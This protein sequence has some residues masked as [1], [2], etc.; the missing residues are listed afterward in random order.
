VNDRPLLS[1]SEA[2]AVVQEKGSRRRRWR[3]V[4]F[5]TPPILATVCVL[6]LAGAAGFGVHEEHHPSQ[7]EHGPAGRLTP[8]GSPRIIYTVPGDTQ[9]P[10]WA[11]TGGIGDGVWSWDVGTRSTINYVSGV[12]HRERV[13]DL[14]TACCGGGDRAFPGLTVGPSGTVWGVLNHTL[15]ELNPVTGRFATTKLPSPP[16]AENEPATDLVM[17]QNSA[18]DVT[19]ASD[20]RELV[21][22]F[23]YAAGVV[24]YPLAGGKLGRPSVIRLPAPD[25]ALDVGVLADGTL[26]V[27]MEEFGSSPR[28]E[29]DI[30]GP[31]GR[32]TRVS[33][34]DSWG[35]TVDGDGWLVGESLP[36]FVTEGGQRRP[37]PAD[38]RLP[39]GDRWGSNGAGGSPNRLV[40]LPGGLI[41]R[42]IQ[43]GSL[44]VASV[45]ANE[46]IAMPGRR[47]RNL[48]EMCGG[49]NMNPEST[50][51]TLVPP[52]KWIWQ[53][54]PVDQIVVDGEGNIWILSATP[55]SSIAFAEITPALLRSTFG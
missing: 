53:R 51:T 38:F 28:P 30:I 2:L 14:G 5:A 55:G 50:T 3:S 54:D 47:V 24:V 10:A 9:D 37:V 18:D 20:G 29:L 27:G 12:T 4:L 17:S 33:V 43:G 15:I 41:G 23:E 39:P 1:T 11:M 19:V 49:C 21:V 45:H 7:I 6:A 36:S 13:Y 34:P 35:V 52:P 48:P 8:E 42:P 32:S 26:G 16:A 46:V 40:L 31:G 44:E 22:G 25:I